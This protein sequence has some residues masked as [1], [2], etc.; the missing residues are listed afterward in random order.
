MAIDFNLLKKTEGIDQDLLQSVQDS[1]FQGTAESITPT[2]LSSNT[3]KKTNQTNLDS[4][5]AIPPK[6]SPD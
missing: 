2:I 6:V 1:P 5:C 3:G 4:R